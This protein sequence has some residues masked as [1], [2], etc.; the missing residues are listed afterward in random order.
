[1]HTRFSRDWS[2]DVCSSDLVRWVATL[3]TLA[4][5]A[6]L[7]SITLKDAAGNPVPAWRAIWPV[8]GATNQLLAGL[9]LLT[10]T[11]WLKRTGRAFIFAAVPMTF[12][13][14][15]TMTALWMLVGENGFTLVGSIA[16]FLFLLGSLLVVEAVRALRA[17]RVEPEPVVWR[18]A[19]VAE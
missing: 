12:M 3:A 15:T 8:F 18:S 6:I 5:P 19:V 10:A 16:V 11:V 2:S 7:L 14:A 17:G 1:R 13:I 9:A 4:L